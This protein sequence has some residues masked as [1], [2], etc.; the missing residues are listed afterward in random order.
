MDRA[1]VPARGRPGKVR[2][3]PGRGRPPG[4]KAGRVQ[5]AGGKV[6]GVTPRAEELALPHAQRLQKLFAA[7]VGMLGQHGPD[8]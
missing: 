3:W 2:A 1:S 6:G 7:E 5:A 4:G 8:H